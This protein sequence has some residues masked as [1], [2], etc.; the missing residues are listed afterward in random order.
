MKPYHSQSLGG[1]P[2]RTGPSPS[3]APYQTPGQIPYGQQFSRPSAS[4]AP[5]PQHQ[6][7]YS[8]HGSVAQAI[9]P[10]TPY[11]QAQPNYSQYGAATQPQP[12]H[13][14][15]QYSQY[16]ASTAPRPSHPSSSSSHGANPA[17]AYNPPR[18]V[19]VYTLADQAN[20]TIPYDI[21]AQFHCDEHG[22]VIFYTA[23]PLDVNAVSESQQSLGHSLRYLAEKAR[24]KESRDKKR[25]ARDAELEQENVARLKRVD[26]ESEAEREKFLSEKITGMHA[27]SKTLYDSADEI[28]KQLHGANWKDVKNLEMA[29]LAVKQE[30]VSGEK[31]ELEQFRKQVAERK[32]IKLEG[33]KWV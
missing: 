4:P 26:L 18:P 31:R 22:R 3:P 27:W 33:F 23:P 24:T 17:N 29:A 20:S 8:S 28:Y 1:Q 19:E 16:Q 9:Q 10:Q 14:V 15:N 32:N 30:A 11:Q 6:Q 7:S 12:N 21:R 13:P 25:K 2:P 5:V